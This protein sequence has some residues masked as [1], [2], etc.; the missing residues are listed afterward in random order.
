MFL[1]KSLLSLS[2]GDVGG[3]VDR[4]RRLAMSTSPLPSLQARSDCPAPMI[5][6]PCLVN[7]RKDQSISQSDWTKNALVRRTFKDF[8]KVKN[9]NSKLPFPMFQSG[10]PH[11]H[12]RADSRRRISM[13]VLCIGLR[14]RGH[15]TIGE[16][17]T[18]T[19]SLTPSQTLRTRPT[20]P[21]ILRVLWWFCWV[22]VWPP[23]FFVIKVV[24]K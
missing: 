12:Q 20:H 17:P 7:T 16:T 2:G 1:W 15:A 4:W 13:S 10:T 24:R 8:H 14:S 3:G 23:G 19:H 9:F 22:A 21:L 6:L 11:F 18:C 5:W